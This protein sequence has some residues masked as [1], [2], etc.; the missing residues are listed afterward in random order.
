MAIPRCRKRPSSICL[1][2]IRTIPCASA[3]LSRLK[4]SAPL[5]DISAASPRTNRHLRIPTVISHDRSVDLD[6]SHSALPINLQKTVV[7][8]SQVDSSDLAPVPSRWRSSAVRSISARS[9][10]PPSAPVLRISDRNVPDRYSQSGKWSILR[11]PGNFMG[12][13]PSR[14]Y[15]ILLSARLL[16]SSDRHGRTVGHIYVNGIDLNAELV[17][18]GAAW[19]YRKYARD[20]DLFDMERDAKLNKRRLWSLPEAEQIPPWNGGRINL[21]S[22]RQVSVFAIGSQTDQRK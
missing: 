4:A 17:K 8:L 15:Q 21:S 19:V 1:I 3:T 18:R 5:T 10:G 11:N 22:G 13:K 12:I 16:L 2:P 20:L 14:N 9:S 7:R 6:E